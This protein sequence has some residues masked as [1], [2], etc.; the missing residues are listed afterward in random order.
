MNRVGRYLFPGNVFFHQ[1]RQY[2]IV[3]WGEL[4]S[5][6]WN[7][8][9]MPKKKTDWKIWSYSYLIKSQKIFLRFLSDKNYFSGKKNHKI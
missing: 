9:E 3:R 6:F 8:C 7:N 4:N 2:L 1:E 5:E